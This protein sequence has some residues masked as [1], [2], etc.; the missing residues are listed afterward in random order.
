MRKWYTIC[1]IDKRSTKPYPAP[2]VLFP[3]AKEGRMNQSLEESARRQ[4]GA[5]L[6]CI[7][8]ICPPDS[9]VKPL[10]RLDRT[11]GITTVIFRDPEGE[12]DDLVLF[13]EA[14]DS[15]W[16]E[17]PDGRHR[18]RFRTFK[19]EYMDGARIV[20]DHTDFEVERTPKELELL[21]MWELAYERNA[22]RKMKA[23]LAVS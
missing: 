21:Q 16:Y 9:L 13:A 2:R 3:L 18:R 4:W 11:K 15:P 5:R 8:I 12:I 1:G 19:A 23:D 10:V 20:I 22:A 17:D 14:V 7:F 6:G